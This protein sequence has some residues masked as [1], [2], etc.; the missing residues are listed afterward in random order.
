[1]NNL[2]ALPVRIFLDSST[3][4]T[5]D[6]YG[7]FI[8]DGE[9]IEADD[10]IWSIP[11]GIESL[12]ALRSIFMV[13]DRANFEFALSQNSFAEVAAKDDRGYLQW[14]YDVLAHWQIALESY[15]SNPFSGD[16]VKL[17]DKLDSPSFGYLGAGDRRLIQDAVHLE[18]DAFLTMERKLPKNADHIERELG[19]RVLT[20]IQYWQLLKPWAAL[21]S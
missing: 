19:I 4:Q 5:L 2:E 21:Y 18:C 12:Q 11:D 3:L 20:P 1:M 13:N 15:D 17:A 10:K 9:E 14:A 16:G 7:A 8:W 6:V